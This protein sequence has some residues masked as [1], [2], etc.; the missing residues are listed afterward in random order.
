MLSATQVD[1]N[2]T[3]DQIN[4][5]LVTLSEKY[6]GNN[7]IVLSGTNT[8][9]IGANIAPLAPWGNLANKYFPTVATLSQ[10]GDNILTKDQLGGYFTPNNL[11]A[12]TYLAKNLTPFININEVKPGV[13]YKYADPAKF[14]KGSGLSEKDQDNIITHIQDLSWLKA[15]NTGTIY[16]GQVIGT[17]DYQK[18]VPY[19]SAYETTKLD[20]NGVVDVRNDYEF[21]TGPQKN[22]WLTTNKFTEEDWLKYHD[23]DNRVQRLLINTGQ[24]LYSWNTD[25][26]GNQYALY[27]APPVEGRTIYHMQN[28]YGPLWVR[29][30]DGIVYSATDALTAIY[31]KYLNEP[32]IYA[33]LSANNIKNLDVFYDTLVFDLSGYTIFEKITFD[34]NTKTIQ[35]TDKDFL[36]LDYHQNVSSRLLSSSSLTGIHVKDSAAVYYGGNW[37]DE[38]KKTITSCLLLSAAVTTTSTTSALVVPVLYQY[39]IN[40]P[41]K[42]TRIF[43]TNN[44]DFDYFTYSRGISSVNSDQELLTYMEAPVITYNKDIGSYIISFVAFIN[45]NFKIV[46]YN[47]KEALLGRILV[48]EAVIP[49]VTDTGS[50]VTVV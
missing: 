23:I 5:Q 47:T 43:P 25:V 17:T 50:P 35:T 31:N 10:S 14:N 20:T 9:Y 32:A 49:I 48:N 18:F 7:V 40:N 38:N 21:W 2:T 3:S 26:F 30:V 24:E 33:Q 13:I 46:T 45:Q 34:Y 12:S 1:V 19:Q 29:T 28:A 27:K 36:W 15:T 6:L 11:G 8:G 39:D 44:T 22:I 41:S 42:R 4:A 16:D 37:Y